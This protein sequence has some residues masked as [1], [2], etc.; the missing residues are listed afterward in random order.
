MS[1]EIDDTSLPP[2]TMVGQFNTLKGKCAMRNKRMFV[3]GAAIGLCLSQS[4]F[5]ADMPAK[6]PVLKAP[7]LKATYNWAGLYVGGNV[8]YGW[9]S[10]A[11]PSRSIVDTSGS[12]L[13]AFFNAGGFPVGA[14]NP[15]GIIGGVQAGYHWQKNALVWGV[16]TDFQAS[17]MREESGF[18]SVAPAPPF[19]TGTT[20]LDRKIDWFGTLRGKAGWAAQNWLFYGT[21][22]LAYGHIK[23][24][25]TFTSSGIPSA[26]GSNDYTKVGWTV[27]AGLEY[28][29]DKWSV[30]VEYLYIDLGRTDAT[31]TFAGYFGAGGDSVTVS[32]R[33]NLNIVRA[34]VNY[35]F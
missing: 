20:T 22:G 23:E 9:A 28:G 19:V 12:G 32:S 35:R 11:D 21:A 34:L 1:N 6:A 15:N 25:L 33:N 13:T 24:N 3:I 31:M 4:A 18:A 29:W 5:A 27:G 16:V 30:G 17:G 14:V 26:S 10:D 7:A 8:G 2:F